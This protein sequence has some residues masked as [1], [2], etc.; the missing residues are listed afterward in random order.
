MERCAWIHRFGIL[1][2]VSVCLSAGA[3]GTIAG[4][5]LA[6]EQPVPGQALSAPAVLSQTR[7]A[8]ATTAGR[9]QPGGYVLSQERYEKAVA[10]SRA[11]YAMYFVSVF[12]S[13]VM[14]V[15]LL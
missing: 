8:Q 11:S 2:C 9:T 15:I 5:V 14:L 7:P 1:F 12:I 6:N 4:T 10:Y 3:R 13:V